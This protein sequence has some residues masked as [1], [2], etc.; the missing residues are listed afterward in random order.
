MSKAKATTILRKGRKAIKDSQLLKALQSEIKFELS[1]PRFENSESGSLG[2]FMM[3]WDSPQSQDVV[4]RKKCESGEELAVSALLG[5]EIKQGDDSLPREALMKVCVAKTGLSPILQFDC[6]ISTKGQNGSELSIQ[7]FYYLQSSGSLGLSV[8]R[9]PLFSDLEPNLQ[10]K[11]KQYLA[12]RGIGENFTSYLL[13]HLHKKEQNQ[14]VN[15]LQKMEAM[16]AEKK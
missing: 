13:L 6:K 2:E 3:D 4:L 7:N 1:H 9:G 11:L 10:D 15:W 16:V 5:D 12:A 8:Y 14:Y